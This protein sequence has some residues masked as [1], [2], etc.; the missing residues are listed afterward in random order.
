MISALLAA[1]LLTPG[2][3]SCSGPAIRVHVDGFANRQGKVRVRLFGPPA[4]SYFDKTRAV[5]RYEV[6]VPRSGPVA[7]CVPVPRPGVYAVDIR[8]DVNGNGKTDR[9]DG[10]GASGNPR[11]SLTD[12][13]FGRRPDPKTVGV[14]VGTDARDVRV[15]LM[16][17]QG[18]SFRPA[19]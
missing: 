17:L 18:T 11:I 16:Y 9:A 7:F 4:S 6:P 19:R 3:S 5:I 12:V 13:I 15:T 8:H 10:G 14:A 1:A 2:N